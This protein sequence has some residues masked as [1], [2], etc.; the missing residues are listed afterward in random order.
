MI[1]IAKGK[2]HHQIPRKLQTLQKLE[3]LMAEDKEYHQRKLQTLKYFQVSIPEE[4]KE[5]HQTP[6]KLQTPS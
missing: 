2:E 5:Y 3:N 1:S 4:D 6:R